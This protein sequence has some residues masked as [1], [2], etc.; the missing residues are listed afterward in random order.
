M[1][2]DL[3]SVQI[4]I[5]LLKQYEIEHIVISAGTRH[6]PFVFSV[7]QDNYFTTYSVVDERSASFFA[8]G[9]IE[10][11][12]KPVAIVCTSGTAACN[13]VS[14]INEAFYQKLPLVVLTADRNQ[15]YLNQ[16][17]E[18]M[19][20]QDGLYGKA[21]KKTVTLPIVRDEKDVW[22]CSR[23]VNEAL[24]EIN[25]G[26]I[27]PVHINFPVEDNYP[28]SNVIFSFNTKEI[29]EANRI[30]RLDVEDDALV[31]K[32]KVEQLR[33]AK[34]M[35]IY[36]QHGK[37]NDEEQKAI[38]R[39]CKVFNCVFSV[40]LLSNML[41]DK[42]IF[43]FSSVNTISPEKFE[44]ILPDIV[45]TMNGHTVSAIKAK[46]NGY[47][48]RFKHWHVSKEGTISD[49][50]KVQTDIIA[51]TNT[52]FFNRFSE[53]AE[54]LPAGNMDMYYKEWKD[55]IKTSGNGMSPNDCNFEFSSVYAIQQLMNQ[56]P[57]GSLLHLANSNSVR[58]AN[59]FSLKKEIEVY[60]NRGTHGI[61]G[62]MSAFIGQACVSS[63]LCYLIIGD[64]SFFYDMNALW[65]RYVGKNVR[66]LVNNN[67][68][69]GIFH[70]PYYQQ[71]NEFKRIDQH[72][73]AAHHT[74]VKAWAEAVGFK[75][76]GVSDKEQMQKALKEF[77]CTS[78]RPMIIETF[79]DKDV[80][81]EQMAQV[82]R[83]IKSY[84]Q[85]GKLASGIP[86]PAKKVLK[87]IL[88]K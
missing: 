25:R 58:I 31:W 50:F 7:E 59:N 6:I 37:V 63:E 5:S 61:D 35:I 23:L 17:E 1:Y 51:C 74:S 53:I 65:N 47:S 29:A 82:T 30:S 70:A 18:Q 15:Y 83:Q 26:E 60:A 41:C 11:I 64:L 8:L 72:I 2:T 34:V 16:Q 4:L 81:I 28:T 9:L 78:D 32:K 22:Y 66:I 79:T 39:F 62:S 88:R 87:K 54:Q 38:N 45:I 75:Y 49:P 48:K 80:D 56:I 21:V 43:T 40:D 69:G 27:G 36:G 52:T 68:G 46:L 24:L 86:E 12:Q 55:A 13:Y 71:G 67:S 57:K 84:T 3:K 20:M 44:T 14:A 73:A 33:K 42:S 10:K 19:V 85:M 77:N 76:F